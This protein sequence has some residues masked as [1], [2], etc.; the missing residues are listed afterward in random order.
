MKILAFVIAVSMWLAFMM[1][2]WLRGKKN[3]LIEKPLPSIETSPTII[4]QTVADLLQDK[5]PSKLNIEESDSEQPV[6]LTGLTDSFFSG[7]QLIKRKDVITI[8]IDPDILTKRI[9][10]HMDPKNNEVTMQI[11]PGGIPHEPNAE[12]DIAESELI[13]PTDEVNEALLS[14]IEELAKEGRATFQ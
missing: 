10:F 14:Q 12:S 11:L 13:T 5:Q 3:K 4:Q 9:Q 7:V 8:N 1:F 6:K 2:I